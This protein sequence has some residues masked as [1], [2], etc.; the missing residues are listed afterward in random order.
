MAGQ[1]WNYRFSESSDTKT[2]TI[3][4]NIC[5]PSAGMCIIATCRFDLW[6]VAFKQ[7]P[8]AKPDLSGHSQRRSLK[9]FRFSLEPLN[10][11]LLGS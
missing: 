5:Y 11:W 1:I 7:S 2:T 4:D 10:P 9:R 6:V 3:N 8:K